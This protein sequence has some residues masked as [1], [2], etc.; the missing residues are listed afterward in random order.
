MKIKPAVMDKLQT[1]HTSF[2][3]DFNFESNI[4]FIQGNSGI[5][6]SAVYSFIQEVAAENKSIRCFNY[7]DQSKNYK[8]TIKN[9]K[10]KLF[11][12]DNADILLDDKMR[13]Y[14]SMDSQNQ[15]VIIGR[16]PSGLLLGLNDIMTLDS[17]ND[18]GRIIFSLK[19]SFCLP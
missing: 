13:Q 2:E 11:V 15:Y 12:I 8:T 1:N 17:R 19:K 14:I 5:G 3:V 6:K 18:N 10:D 4:T 7:L 9:S 16:N